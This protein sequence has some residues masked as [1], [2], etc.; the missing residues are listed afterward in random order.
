MHLQTGLNSLL[1]MLLQ[2]RNCCRLLYCAICGN[3][4]SVLT[5][6]K[7]DKKYFE[8]RVLERLTII[9]LNEF[10]SV[11]YYI[12]DNSRGHA[13]HKS[14]DRWILD[15]KSVANKNET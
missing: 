3:A 14:K 12:N 5:K 10:T 11:Y 8:S 15:L 6:L 9:E 2:G 1:E 13:I 7:N 4:D